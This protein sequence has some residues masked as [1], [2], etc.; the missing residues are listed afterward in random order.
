VK[1]RPVGAW[2]A[3][4]AAT[5]LGADSTLATPAA[6]RYIFPFHND[7]GGTILRYLRIYNLVGNPTAAAANLVVKYKAWLSK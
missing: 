5:R 7:F 2:F 1:F 4:F 3:G 6:G